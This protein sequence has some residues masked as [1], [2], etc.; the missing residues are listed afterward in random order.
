MIKKFLLLFLK[1]R[2]ETAK[3]IW[4]NEFVAPVKEIRISYLPPLMVY[5]AA[6]VAG[7]TGV[8]ASFFV[9][10][11]LGL[12]ANFLAIIAF[13]AGIWWGFKMPV[14]H[15]VDLLWR[16]KAFFIFLGAAL[17]TLGLSIMVGLTGYLDTMTK[18]MSAESWYII[19]ALI[20]PFA[21]ILQDVVADAM[22]VEA[23]PRFTPKGEAIDE[24][25]LKKEHIT[26]QLLGRAVI[27]FGGLI[28]AGAGGW[29][30]RIPA[31]E[32]GII[33]AMIILGI[34]SAISIFKL[35][36]K[37]FVI[38]LNRILTKI[39]A[40]CVSSIAILYLYA[41]SLKV[42]I[43][44]FMEHVLSDV[45][46]YE[47]VYW[48]A[49]IVPIISVTGVLIASMFKRRRKK[50]LLNKGFSLDK[51]K[52]M[53]SPEESEKTKINWW[54]LGGSG[55]YLMIL[56]PL[57]LI[58]LTANLLKQK[59]GDGKIPIFDVDISVFPQ[60][61]SQNADAVLLF[62]S[63]FIVSFL[64]AKLIKELPQEGRRILIGTAIFIFVYRATPSIGAGLNFFYIEVLQISE[65]FF[66]TIAQI[67][68]I[69]ALLG[70]FVLRPMMAKKSLAW[71]CV[72]LTLFYSFFFLPIIGLVHGLHEWIAGLFNA[73]ALNTA[74]AIIL[75]DV[76]IESPF[77][78]V[79][80]VPMLAWIAQ[81][82]PTKHKATYFAVMASFT[83]LALSASTLG[84]RY[85]NEIFVI[86]KP[87]FNRV[88]ELVKAGD[89]TELPFILWT[90]FSISL[91]FPIL[92]IVL[93]AKIRDKE[94][95]WFR[96]LSAVKRK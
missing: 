27:I 86:T 4:K 68:S 5:F 74:K 66:G 29:F 25:T 23:I 91:V 46:P 48:L 3:A 39:I 14:G 80:M 6:G 7:L 93:F 19:S 61:F 73:N 24:K 35:Y 69:I 33:L 52:T 51:I 30:A 63:L 1:A 89:Y 38:K 71:I 79:A 40:A 76:V 58:S 32:T 18:H 26:M 64:I 10:K 34:F 21:F 49:M 83:N 12:E 95:L 62:G 81:Y 65:G 16:F 70:L 42:L 45:K 92:A 47:M 44:P 60:W 78:Q 90:V 2:F 87:T 41:F 75:I 28:V 20:T 88:G 94:P 84:T 82:A 15:L 53:L 85:L 59:M 37:S 11:V 77:G 54:I 55:V 31:S 72:F 8:V 50:E 56:I 9:T 57:G 13:W 36:K 22:T 67:G 43:E 96:F 17:M